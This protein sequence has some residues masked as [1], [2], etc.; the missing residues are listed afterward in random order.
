M[1]K[2]KKTGGRR[3][4]T[5]N[6]ATAEVKAALLN[7]FDQ[8][9]GV[10]SLTKWA[11]ENPT[12]FYQLWAKLLPAEIKSEITGKDGGPIQAT[13]ALPPPD[14]SKLSDEELDA[15]CE[16]AKKTGATR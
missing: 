14:F 13:G 11:K 15:L 3:A 16:M 9:G 12:P 1:A 4:G 2:G 5:T 10:D 6:K 7:A 8:L